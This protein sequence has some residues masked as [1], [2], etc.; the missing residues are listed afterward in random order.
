MRR[1]Q[2]LHSLDG[3]F[4]GLQHEVAVVRPRV[5]EVDIERGECLEGLGVFFPQ[6]LGH[7]ET[8]TASLSP[9][10]AACLMQCRHCTYNGKRHIHTHIAQML[11]LQ[12]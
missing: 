4:L 3:S 11:L 6:Q 1:Q 8:S 9:P 5:G 2:A 10:S 12:L 7:V